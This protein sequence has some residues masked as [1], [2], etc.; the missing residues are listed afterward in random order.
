MKY[1]VTVKSGYNTSRLRTGGLKVYTVKKEL[2]DLG[3][4]DAQFL[5]RNY[6]M[7]RFLE[8]ISLSKYKDKSILKG[9]MLITAMVGLDARLTMGL[10]AAVKGVN[11]TVKDVLRIF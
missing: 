8:R 3:V 10:D 6:V 11:A 1:S 5:M 7:E 2:I 9:G 4:T